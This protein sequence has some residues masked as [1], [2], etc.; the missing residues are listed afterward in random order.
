QEFFFSAGF[1]VFFWLVGQM[2]T[3]ELAAANVLT[4]FSTVLIL[5]AMSLGM[6]SAT[7]ISKTVGE[8][9]AA[10][11]ARWGWDSANLGVSAITLLGLPLFLFP[12]AFLSV[13]LTDPN[14]ISIAVIPLQIAAVGTG[15][16]SL[17]YI[18]AFPLYSM[19][20]GNRVMLVSLSTQ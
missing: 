1:V 14:T 13:F 9:D 20:D 18:F 16:V 6:A 4:R 19:G 3:A 12:R 7:L 10:G 2:G 17:I 11:A 15:A 8:G 5:L